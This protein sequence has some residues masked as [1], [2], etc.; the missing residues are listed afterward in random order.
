VRSGQPFEGIRDD[1]FVAHHP[2]RD[3]RRAAP[4]IQLVEPVDGV[5]RH[6]A[7]A[8]NAPEPFD[9]GDIRIPQ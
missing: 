8:A 4:W 9:V 5:S 3:G 7:V 6:R 2:A 1:C